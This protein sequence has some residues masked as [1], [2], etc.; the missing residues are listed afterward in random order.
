MTSRQRILIVD[1]QPTNIEIL[2]NIFPDYDKM[3]ALNGEQALIA[4]QSQPPPDLIFLDIMM[5]G[6]DG[7]EV[8]RHLKTDERT[9][10]IPVIFVT[11]K[12]DAIA[13]TEGLALGAADYITKPIS[14]PVVRARVQTHLALQRQKD[15]LD[16]VV[17]KRTA[18][19]TESFEIIKM[20]EQHLENIMA[21]A[22]DAIISVGFEGQVLSL[23]PAA[24]RMFGY[25]RPDAIGLNLV[26]FIM[27][28]ELLKT[29]KKTP[30][31]L[32]DQMA[33]ATQSGK[34]IEF[35][36]LRK[37]NTN[38]DC[39]MTISSVE[40]NGKPLYTCFVRDITERN[41]LLKTLEQAVLAAESANKAKSEFLSN[42]SH[43]IRSPM[44]AISGMTELVL[45]SQLTED[46]RINLEI[47]QE[48]SKNLLGLIND[49]LDLSKIEAQQ[50]T[51]ERIPFDLRGQLEGTCD[52]LAV[53][54]HKKELELFLDI[55][56]DVSESLIGDPLRLKQIVINL[57]NNAIKFTD[58]GEVVVRVKPVPGDKNG[59]DDIRLHFLVSDT[60]I[61]IPADRVE[62]IFKRFTQ[63]DGS[64][65]RKYGG[66]GLGLTICRHLTAMMGGHIGVESKEGRGSVFYF[67]ACFE[68]GQRASSDTGRILEQRQ[69]RPGKSHL[70]DI[71]ILL[72]DQNATSRI[73]MKG[74]LVR[75]GAS[76]EEVANTAALLASWQRS[77]DTNRAFDAILLD[78]GLA[79]P[80]VPVIGQRSPLP[81]GK[82]KLILLLP[83]T[84]QTGNL[85]E[86]AYFQGCQVLKK[87][88]KL[89]PLL[90]AIDRILG[91]VV[92]ITDESKTGSYH[93]IRRQ[94]VP[95]RILLVEDL[96]NNQKLATTILEQAG[97]IV[98]LA[99]NGLECLEHMQ[100]N[101]FDLVLMD[102][103]MPEI[104][105]FE[106]THRIRN[107]TG[108]GACDP[109]I[110][111]V[112]VTVLVTKEDEAQ[113]MAAGMN[114]YLRKP[115]RVMEL[116]EVIEPFT[117]GRPV[118][119]KKSVRSGGTPVLNPMKDTERFNKMWRVFLEEGPRHMVRLQKALDDHKVRLVL[120][121]LRWIMTT[122]IDIGAN[123]VRTRAIRLKGTA[124][125]KD[126]NEAQIIGNDLEQEFLR[127]IQALTE[128]GE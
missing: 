71:R 96:V 28:T 79:L 116:L 122:A 119:R 86:V 80:E 21:F 54:A 127:V 102:M 123:R 47:V 87:P 128:K 43:E 11:G 15:D 85:P 94:T 126:W 109:Q 7:Y 115:Y 59:G 78:H 20:R 27:G 33:E 120:K 114:G 124:E 113:C 49:I 12:A 14:R 76:V 95:L 73:I 52:A 32:K 70:V 66:T 63:A 56:S 53:M 13:E 61:G 26:Q 36:G 84:M 112:A 67:T 89:Y 83:A 42:M 22:M 81:S 82:G 19:L 16:K 92:T 55:A 75:F 100:N 23:N 10:N 74:M 30:A 62:S 18:E 45:N 6:M 103:N 69:M 99:N 60:G 125:L 31:G 48:S 44:N 40:I 29:G 105:G 3:V 68:V 72:G 41:R 37:D 5:P 97:H 2:G 107:G 51:L 118:T 25:S 91:R 90:K 50:L 1:D 58:E 121:E 64:T 24:E 8:C 88:I 111:I 34:S 38:I 106:A 46:Q 117:R 77:T 39:E 110:P 93:R 17:K 101:R 104:G 98:T 9:V 57:V 108:C 65:T 4:A 35:K